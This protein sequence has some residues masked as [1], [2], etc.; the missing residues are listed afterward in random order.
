MGTPSEVKA[1]IFRHMLDVKSERRKAMALHQACV[2]RA[3]WIFQYDDKCGSEYV[4]LPAYVRESAAVATRWKYRFGLQGNL[5]PGALLR[6]SFVPPCLHT[7]ANFGC[8]ALFCSWLRLVAMGKL[9]HSFVRMSD[10]GSDN[11][12]A[13]TH[14]FHWLAINKGIFQKLEWIRLMPKHSHNYAD[15][16]NSMIKQVV[17]PKKG[18]EGDCLAP[19]DMEQVINKAMATQRGEPELAWQW[20]NFDWVNWFKDQQLISNQFADFSDY[21]HWIYEV[22]IAL[23]LLQHV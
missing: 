6:F 4:H 13:V 8:T 17:Q 10:S 5:T 1:E 15:R 16:A 22:C 12:A 18:T 3:G 9:G 14:A 11:N 23:S 7:G 21:R 2:V 20:V 19:W